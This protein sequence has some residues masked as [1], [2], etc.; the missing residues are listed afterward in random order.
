MEELTNE[1][2]RY[3]FRRIG[4]PTTLKDVPDVFV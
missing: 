3:R 4:L 1:N 2:I